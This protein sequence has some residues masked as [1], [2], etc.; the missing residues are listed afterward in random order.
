MEAWNMGFA[1]VSIF[2]K[3]KEFLSKLSEKRRVLILKGTEP[4]AVIMRH[5]EYESL[6]S[7]AQMATQMMAQSKPTASDDGK[8]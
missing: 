3:A 1:S 7:L 8:K 4:V 6:C 2:R 5:D